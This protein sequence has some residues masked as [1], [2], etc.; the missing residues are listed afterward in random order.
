[1]EQTGERGVGSS[2]CTVPQLFLL[3][4]AALFSILENKL[5][6][7][8]DDSTL[9]AQLLSSPDG[10]VA[11]TESLNRELNRVSM[12]CD[13]WG[14]KLNE[15]ETKTMILSMSRTIHP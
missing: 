10:R 1:M 14:I 7:Y 11:I 9:V 6:G 8:A 4:T 3:Y 5:Y 2:S 15:S 12:W 13:L